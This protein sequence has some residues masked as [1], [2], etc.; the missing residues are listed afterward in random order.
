MCWWHRSVVRS[1]RCDQSLDAFSFWCLLVDLLFELRKFWA[2]WGLVSVSCVTDWAKEEAI[3]RKGSTSFK[4]RGSSPSVRCRTQQKELRGLFRTG[5]TPRTWHT[6]PRL[7]RSDPVLSV[8]TGARKA[9]RLL[10]GKIAE[11][12]TTH[13]PY[14]DISVWYSTKSIYLCC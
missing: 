13:T 2:A 5:Q 8:H 3:W 7:D 6:W 4:Q 10:C 11:T 12:C 9:C 1:Q 14:V